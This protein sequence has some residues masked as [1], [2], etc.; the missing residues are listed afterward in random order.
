MIKA[1]ALII[2]TPRLFNRLSLSN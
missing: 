2:T 1:D